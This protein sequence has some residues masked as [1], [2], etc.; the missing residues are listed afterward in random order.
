[1]LLAILSSCIWLA[2]SLDNL[3]LGIDFLNHVSRSFDELHCIFRLFNLFARNIRFPRGKESNHGW[4]IRTCLASRKRD[5]RNTQRRVIEEAGENGFHLG[6]HRNHD[7]HV[8]FLT[9]RHGTTCTYG[10]HSFSVA[11]P[12]SP[13][14]LYLQ[15]DDRTLRGTLTLGCLCLTSNCSRAFS[16]N[17]G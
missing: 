10:A 5:K 7:L 14:N 2:L 11:D 16:R 4:S 17:S 13:L 6:Q 15:R 8:G 1:M 12:A 3:E 9:P